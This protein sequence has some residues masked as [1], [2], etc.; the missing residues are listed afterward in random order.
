V[1]QRDSTALGLVLFFSVFAIGG[2]LV[3]WLTDVIS[4]TDISGDGWSLRGNG[5]LIVPVVLGPTLMAAGWADLTL[6]FRGQP[7]GLVAGLLAGL[8]TIVLTAVAGLA[9]VIV[10]GI[11]IPLATLVVALGAGLGLARSFGRP[12]RATYL[13]AAILFVLALIGGELAGGSVTLIA[14]L[15]M[16]LL[17]ALPLLTAGGNDEDSQ[18]RETPAAW[19]VLGYVGLPV[20]VVA[21]FMAATLLA[22]PILAAG[23]PARSSHTATALPDG[24]VLVVGGSGDHGPL[25]TTWL[26]EPAAAKW[27]QAPSM[28]VARAE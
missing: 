1:Y 8:I 2:A 23:N 25:A 17:I 24:R 13:S 14:P 27:T 15:L 5:A 19:R 11:P 22:P 10:P 28:G 6:W 7:R 9:P 26:Y 18:S 4:R 20:A 12:A 16:P 3:W 21:G